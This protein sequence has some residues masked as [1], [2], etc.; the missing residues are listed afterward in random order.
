MTVMQSEKS[1]QSAAAAAAGVEA[2]IRELARTEGFP[3]GAPSGDTGAEPGSDALMPLI[4]KIVAP[5]VAELER[6]IGQLQEA[7]A[8]LQSE[9]ERVQREADHYL[10]LSKTASESVRVISGAVAEWRNAGHP[11]Q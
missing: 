6:L 2:E 1:I 11:I 8:Y 9:G 10:A 7:R 4:E 3:A 5:S